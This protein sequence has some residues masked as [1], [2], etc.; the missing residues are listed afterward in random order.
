MAKLFLSL[1]ILLFLSS[2]ICHLLSLHVCYLNYTHY[3][4]CFFFFSWSSQIYVIFLYIFLLLLPWLFTNS[5]I[6]NVNGHF[7][8]MC[9]T[10]PL[11]LH[12]IQIFGPFHYL[13]GSSVSHILFDSLFSTPPM[14]SILKQDWIMYLFLVSCIHF[15]V[16]C[17]VVGSCEFSSS[18]NLLLCSLIV[19]SF[20]SS[21]HGLYLFLEKLYLTELS[22]LFVIAY[23]F[24]HMSFYFCLLITTRPSRSSL[25][26]HFLVE[27]SIHVI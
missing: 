16:S 5:H 26:L 23:S 25:P 15:H 8:T 2:Q 19:A 6:G 12:R 3:C 22:S 14:L 27:I 7:I 20:G 1:E 4:Y 10:S 21:I 9:S 24:G 18:I 17:L 11:I 13:K